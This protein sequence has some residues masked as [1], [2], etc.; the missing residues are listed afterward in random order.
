[1]TTPG[2]IVPPTPP[3]RLSERFAQLITSDPLLM[4]LLRRLN[5]VSHPAFSG[6]WR[7]VAGCLY[8]AVWND[9]A[10]E[11]LERG[12]NDYDVAYFDPGD[13]SYEAEDQVIRE[14]AGLVAPLN[15]PVEVR[16][17]A[18]VH[19]WFGDHFGVDI[20]PHASV[21]HA[22]DCYAAQTHKVGV[23]LTRDDQ[24]DIYAPDR[25]LEYIYAMRLVPNAT[26]ANRTTYERKALRCKTLWPSLQIE[27]WPT[28]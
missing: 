28:V 3:D 6:S 11:P 22:I 25:A 7:L 13:L 1:M 18:R 16:N 5:H 9:L 26:L 23:R 24:I 8:Q 21:E 4:S 2:L 15:I 20:A 10:G 19:L 12:V 27:P 17:Q 14:V